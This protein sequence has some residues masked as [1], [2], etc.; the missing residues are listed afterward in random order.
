MRRESARSEFEAYLSTYVTPPGRWRGHS[1]RAGLSKVGGHGAHH[2]MMNHPLVGNNSSNS[3]HHSLSSHHHQQQQ[4]EDDDWRHHRKSTTLLDSIPLSHTEHDDSPLPTPQH[5]HRYESLTCLLSQSR[6]PSSLPGSDGRLL[7][8]DD[9]DES[10]KHLSMDNGLLMFDNDE[11]NDHKNHRRRWQ[12]IFSCSSC[13]RRR[14]NWYNNN[15]QYDSPIAIFIGFIGIGTF[16]IVLGLLFPSSSDH[17][18]NSDSDQVSNQP[19]DGISNILGYTYVISWTLSFY[20]QIITNY[21]YPTRAKDGVSL[22]FIIW[23]IVGFTCYSIYTT[24][25]RYSKVVRNEYAN[26]FGND[27]GSGEVDTNVTVQMALSL[28]LPSEE[29]LDYSQFNWTNPFNWTWGNSTDDS[30]NSTNSTGAESHHDDD[31]PVVPQV[32]VNDVV[33][34]W[35]ALILATITFVQIAWISNNSSKGCCITNDSN[36]EVGEGGGDIVMQPNFPI[37]GDVSCEYASDGGVE[38]EEPLLLEN[39]NTSLVPYHAGK[40]N[41]HW[42]QRISSTTKILIVLLLFICT[43]GAIMV[44][45]KIGLGYWGGGDMWQWIDYLYFLSF[46]KVGVSVVKY[47]PQVSSSLF[48]SALYHDIIIL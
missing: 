32:K 46:V 18:H 44:E 25:F 30:T 12:L 1:W 8:L 4:Q 7:L 19:W 9:D 40:E 33:F 48:Y 39:F 42:T 47:I 24:C 38:S 20:P 3:P 22:D 41:E 27:R 45:C 35:H 28:L 26:R 31:T 14:S 37:D 6:T 36:D 17:N 15:I 11:N 43:I 34:A 23:N 21:K 10:Y 2:L 29:S 13:W 5:T 16:G